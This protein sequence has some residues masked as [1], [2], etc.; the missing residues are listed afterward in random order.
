MQFVCLNWAMQY[1]TSAEKM[2]FSKEIIYSILKI[3]TENRE[4]LKKLYLYVSKQIS[5]LARRS[6]AV[7]G[8]EVRGQG[9]SR[10]RKNTKSWIT[11][12]PRINLI[13]AVVIF[14]FYNIVGIS[15]KIFY[16]WFTLKYS[17]NPG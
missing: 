8:L 5:F 13:S 7:S 16:F 1:F 4:F 2:Y 10:I 15:K 3:S 12:S 17:T 9:V 14:D 11:R 6:S